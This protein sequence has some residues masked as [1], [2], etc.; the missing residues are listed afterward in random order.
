[1]FGIKTEIIDPLRKAMKFYR[2]LEYDPVKGWMGI[3]ERQGEALELVTKIEATDP[4]VAIEILHIISVAHQKQG[5]YGEAIAL[6]QKISETR[7][8]ADGFFAGVSQHLPPHL[9][10]AR[11]R[12]SL[13]LPLLCPV[14]SLRRQIP[15][16]YRHVLEMPA[17]CSGHR[18]SV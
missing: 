9:R 13:R 8:I 1:M 18:K 4:E 5:N 7:K 12:Q 3:I 6:R 15:R 11:L 14:P 16:V 2:S 10:H 17:A